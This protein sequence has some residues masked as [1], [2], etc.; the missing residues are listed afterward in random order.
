MRDG[1]ISTPPAAASIL[2][3]IT[4]ASVKQIAA[5]LGF[6]VVARNITRGELYGAD[7]L[8]LTGTAAEIV[9]SRTTKMF[10]P[11]PSET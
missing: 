4:S 5:D 1:R 7:E 9:P 3:G 6:E 10:S 11:E 8:F 2:E